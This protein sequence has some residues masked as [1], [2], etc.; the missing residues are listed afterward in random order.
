MRGA[1]RRTAVGLCV[2]RLGADA[3]AQDEEIF[4][5]APA[6]FLILSRRVSAESKDAGCRR[7]GYLPSGTESGIQSPAGAAA[8][9]ARQRALKIY[10][11][12]SAARVADAGREFA[13]GPGQS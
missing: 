11:G 3:P 9:E 8:R 1:Y 5:V 12:R 10:A 4:F 6:M 2:L 7:R 13:L